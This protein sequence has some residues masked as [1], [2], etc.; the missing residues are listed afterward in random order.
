M[1]PAFVWLFFWL[2]EDRC[3]PE[4]KRYIFYAFLA[5]M[6]AVP[7]V[8]PFEDF[9]AQYLT[10]F[11]LLLAWAALEETFKFTA[12]YVA[13]LRKRVFDEPLDAIIYMVTAALG[14]SALENVLFLF[15]PLYQGDALHAFVLGDLRFMGATLIHT[16]ASATIGFALAF[17]FYKSPRV[18]R[19]SAL[20]GVIL[21]TVLHACFNFFILQGSDALIWTF[22][23]LWVGIIVVLLLVERTKEPA[24]DYC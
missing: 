23:L 24:K 21:A 10:G 4:P 17:S 6:I 1:L 3:Q 8:L 11:S 12:A 16:L 5:G 14:F 13:A 20:G 22:V 15:T 9:A 2:M 7:L 18:R 19:W